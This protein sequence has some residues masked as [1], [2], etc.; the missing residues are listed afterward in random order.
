[1]VEFHSPLGVA[2]HACLRKT[3]QVKTILTTSPAEAAGFV[4]SGG[5]VAFPTETVYGLGANV[6]DEA[7]IAKVFAAKK[8]PLDNPLIAHVAT[9][10]QIGV[11]VKET[12]DSARRLIDVFFPGPLTVVL[13]KRDDIPSIAT[14]GLD[15]IGVRIPRSPLA[16][17]L[18]DLCRAPVVA[19][20]AN[21]SGCPSPTTWHA[22][23]EDLNG[24]IDCI[25]QGDPTEIG[26]ESTVVD[27]MTEPPRVLR[28]GAVSVAQLQEVVPTIEVGGGTSD[29]PARSPGL[30]HQHYSPSA[31]VVV[32]NADDEVR[33]I[34][35]AGYIGLSAPNGTPRMKKICADVDE[36]ARSVFHFF[37]EGDRAGIK[38]IYC[39]EIDETGIGAA[40]MDRIRRASE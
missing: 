22:V 18:L 37:R 3:F 28:P 12:T 15:S 10:E 39:E 27:C 23:F 2:F 40:L 32:I 20:S 24:R 1:V 19:P 14:A 6:F 4:R 25:L 16:Q 9:T 26:L 8:R 5:I 33:G 31:K 17:E 13:R 35:N 38:T 34:E 11:V 29:T 7:A 21:R 30:R 36:Y